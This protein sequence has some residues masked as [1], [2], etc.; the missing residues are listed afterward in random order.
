MFIPKHMKEW[1]PVRGTP[2]R[3]CHFCASG[4]HRT[5]ELIHVLEAPMR[6]DFCNEAC[7]DTWQQTRHDADM[8]EWL[9]LGAGER[10]KIQASYRHEE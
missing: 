1:Q 8:I 4:P 3:R 5:S 6:Y 10:A 2:M 7:L 9:K